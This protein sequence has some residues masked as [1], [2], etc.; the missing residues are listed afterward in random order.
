MRVH[1]SAGNRSICFQWAYLKVEIIYNS[2]VF[3]I[4]DLL[5]ESQVRVFFLNRMDPDYDFLWQNFVRFTIENF[6]WIK[7]RNSNTPTRDA[8]FPGEDFTLTKCS[9][10]MKFLH[11]FLLRGYF[12]P[13]RIRIKISN[14]LNPDPIRIHNTAFKG[15]GGPES[16]WIRWIRLYL[17]FARS[18]SVFE[19]QL[20]L[21]VPKIALFF[22]NRS[23]KTS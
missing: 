23:I 6:C 2:A 9:S 13:A 22:Q 4:M 10:N 14:L 21:Q 5:S 12:C 7:N 16:A 8:H 11:F 15:V 3:R 20:S 19:S 1:S 17:S 18:G